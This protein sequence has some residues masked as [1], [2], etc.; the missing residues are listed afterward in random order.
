MQSYL[1]LNNSQISD[2]VTKVRGKLNKQNRTTLGALIVLDVHSRDVLTKLVKDG[3]YICILVIHFTV[4]V[5]TKKL[6]KLRY[7]FFEKCILS[8]NDKNARNYSNQ[9]ML[10]KSQNLITFSIV[11]TYGHIS[12]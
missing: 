1:E 8:W 2:I 5:S 9:Q 12:N 4:I 11:D 6:N 3:M 7:Q 10:E